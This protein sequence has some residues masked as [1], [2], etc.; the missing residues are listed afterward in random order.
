MTFAATNAG[1]F[2]ISDPVPIQI[3]KSI[4]HL[5]KPVQAD[6]MPTGTVEPY[7]TQRM[8]GGFFGGGTLIT[9]PG[10]ANGGAAVFNEKISSLGTGLDLGLRFD[11]WG[12]MDP[13]G[14]SGIAVGSNPATY[15]GYT[16]SAAVARQAG[17]NAGT[18]YA[19]DVVRRTMRDSHLP[20]MFLYSTGNTLGL[21]GHAAVSGAYRSYEY[22][23]GYSD[24]F[25]YTAPDT[26][27]TDASQSIY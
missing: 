17:F 13:T 1:L 20:V 24:V 8:G 7:I 19:R 25:V 12:F 16:S 10:L 18:I 22:A 27:P 5:T 11:G 14:N 2:N 3:Q 26:S 15:W 23:G 6:G 9:P 21:A 4:A